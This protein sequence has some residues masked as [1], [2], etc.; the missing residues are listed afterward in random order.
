MSEMWRVDTVTDSNQI[1]DLPLKPFSKIG[2]MV[3]MIY[4]KKI[5]LVDL[6][7]YSFQSV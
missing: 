2:S 6:L 4:F 5:Q 1:H 3:C 7:R